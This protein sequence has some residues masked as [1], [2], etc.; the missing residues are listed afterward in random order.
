QTEQP[1]TDAETQEE[2]APEQDEKQLNALLRKAE[3]AFAKGNKG[4]LLSRVEC[5]KWCH[6]VYVL[7][8]EQEHKDRAFTSKL[9]FN[10]LSVHADSKR[11][12]DGSELAKLYKAVEL[13]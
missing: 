10:R 9:I 13:L 7:R 12:C 8:L 2:Q 6:A 11:E 4:L 5:G 1:E 3:M